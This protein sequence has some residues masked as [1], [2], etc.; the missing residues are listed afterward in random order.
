METFGIYLLKSVLWLTGFAIVYFL[1][2]RNERFFQL[3]RAYLLAGI[4][5]SVILPVIS[6]HYKVEVPAPPVSE[7]SVADTG[8]ATGSALP[9]PVQVKSFDYS[10]IVLALYIS[11]ILFLGYRIVRHIV[12]IHKALSKASINSIGP[13]R[14]VRISSFTASFS[15]FNYVFINPSVDDAEVR[16]IMNHELVHVHQKH[17]LDLLL[18]EMLRLFQWINPF[19]WIY[20]GFIRLNNEYLADSLAIQRSSNPGNYKAALMNQLFRSPVIS[21]TSSFN[22]SLNKKRFDMMKKIIT[23]PYRK[24]KVL[25]ILPVFAIVLYAFA[26]PEYQYTALNDKTDQLLMIPET[27]NITV[28]GEVRNVDGIPLPNVTIIITGTTTGTITDS[29]GKFVIGDVPEDGTLVFSCSGYL[30]QTLKADQQ[31]MIVRLVKTAESQDELNTPVYK[32]S[33]QTPGTVNISN[34]F[35]GDLANILI[36]I[37]GVVT[38]RENLDGLDPGDIES[39]SVRKDES[40]TSLYGEKGKNGVILIK[41]KNNLQ[42]PVKGVVVD[43]GGKPLSGV[44]IT[45]TGTSG[46]AR[47]SETG[48]DGRFSFDNV[49]PDASL[50]FFCR[51]YKQLT[52]KPDFVSE[53]KVIMEVDPDYK[54]PQGTSTNTPGVPAPPREL[55]VVDGVISEKSYFEVIRELGYNMGPVKS[56]FGKDATDKY[57]EKGANGVREITT[58]KKAIEMGQKVPLPRL[59]PTDYPTFQGQRY[60]AFGD[61]VRS[62]AK[63]PDEAKEKNIEGWVSVNFTVELDGTVS[64]VRPGGLGAPMLVDEISRVI[65]SSPKWDPPKNPEVDSPF[66]VTVTLKFMLPDQILRTEPYVVVEQMPMYP[67]GDVALLDFIKDNTRYPEE[68][69]AQKIEGRVIV[70]F[71]VSAE[72]RTEAISV[73][74]GVHP[75]LDAE[76]IRVVSSFPKFEP[77]MQGGKP[78]DVWYMC[79]VSFS[80]TKTDTPQQNQ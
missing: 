3:K 71:V 77:G 47:M 13:A 66:D 10:I 42:K 49:Q 7:F 51:G 21:L 35:D 1:F 44:Y 34:A 70:R 56:L 54:A 5:V 30:T 80:L 57:G 37:D 39:M 79:P 12:L 18:I 75:L 23:S 8:I 64:N 26:K 62:Q 19:V 6:I 69:R 20:T 55:V 46:N 38:D 50:L 32:T 15:F 2:L 76:A 72:G 65:N 53:M 48:S 25:L 27:Q 78:V 4:L 58:R 28:R 68:A 63:Y 16:E 60:T 33:T 43:K 59:A 67:G 73:I 41:T 31:D 14:L 40:A 17:W 11:G 61:W 52:L 9:A 74:R 24:L 36:I 29:N 45:S 22:Y